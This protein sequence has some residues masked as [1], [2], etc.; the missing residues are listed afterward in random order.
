[1][2]QL[3]EDNVIARLVTAGRLSLLLTLL[4][5]VSQ[6]ACSTPPSVV[7][8]ADL[9]TLEVVNRTNQPVW[10]AVRGKFERV[11]PGLSR[12]RIRHL[13]PG[14][15]SLTATVKRGGAASQSDPKELPHRTTVKLLGAQSIT[16]SFGSEMAEDAIP[17]LGGLRV[18]NT[19][20]RDLR[21]TLNGRA[22]GEVLAGATRTFHDVT[23]GEYIGQA[24]DRSLK[25]VID[26]SI[27]INGEQTTTWKIAQPAGHLTII[28]DT[29]E[30]VDF[31]INDE[32]LGR[33]NSLSR[34]AFKELPPGTHELVGTS[35]VTRHRY[36]NT[37]VIKPSVMSTW[38]LKTGSGTL[39]VVNDTLEK[40]TVVPRGTLVPSEARTLD[41]EAG[42][43]VTVENVQPGLMTLHA[44]GEQEQILYSTQAQID[45]GQR[46]TW[47]VQPRASTG[48]VV[49]H[50]P[51]ELSLYAAGQR[52]GLLSPNSSTTLGDLP[53]GEVEL[54]AYT[55]HGH[56]YRKM[57]PSESRQPFTWTIET[58]TGMV[59]VTNTRDSSIALY[60]NARFI[61][62]LAPQ[63]HVTFTGVP[64]GEQLFEA[65]DGRSSYV[66][67]HNVTI[68]T[69]TA[70]S[71]TITRQIASLSIHND[72]GEALKVNGNWAQQTA[73]IQQNSN[74]HFIA[75]PGVRTLSL[76]GTRSDL[77]FVRSFDLRAGEQASWRISKPVGSIRVLNE[78]DES[79]AVSLDEN[80][81]LIIPSHGFHD[82]QGVSAGIHRLKAAGLSTGRLYRE[83]RRIQ[84]DGKT[85]WRLAQE[86]ARLLVKNH[87]PSDILIELDGRPYGR[88]FG[89][90]TKV[91][92][93]LTPGLRKLRSVAL[94]NHSVR[95]HDI[96]LAGGRTDTVTI[97][98][99]RGTVL[100]EN[101]SGEHIQIS[102]D[103]TVWQ[104]AVDQAPTELPV[105][106]GLRLIRVKRRDS[107]TDSVFRVNVR[108][109]RSIHLRVGKPTAKIAVKN[110]G[111][112]ALVVFIGDRELGVVEAGEELISDQLPPGSIKLIARGANGEIS[113]IEERT[114]RAGKTTYWH[115]R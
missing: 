64:V 41:I 30:P 62:D 112:A 9:A 51:H 100:V 110:S 114:L 115:L 92:G 56:A 111:Q 108:P 19:L 39:T 86:E 95:H 107:Q 48:R 55:R 5:I 4:L 38:G 43:S 14:N 71:L 24:S 44:I 54:V 35:A 105:D 96:R 79:L 23:A 77:T 59:K 57:L 104:M 73:T 20:A 90:S 84:P 63:A 113:H 52:M 82:F 11:I 88:V 18:T 98:P 3:L 91:F 12:A 21:L 85:T 46:F 32:A 28:N 72:S 94:N 89:G 6:T 106:A 40:L 22:L 42:A 25:T 45:K 29:E 58:A 10:L 33:V 15:A 74:G 69:D 75:G 1:M 61:G 70:A 17:A 109:W 67:R 66:S 76:V 27:Q 47:T 37:L 81:P 53:A 87:D 93:G 7:G 13:T 101:V 34:R 16:W 50:T 99:S 83:N 60:R 103:D 102:V 97:H 68:T 2:K 36:Q 8:G 31:I 80:Q 49:N 26:G 65:V 78:L